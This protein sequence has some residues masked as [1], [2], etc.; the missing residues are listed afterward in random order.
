M[1]TNTAKEGM[2]E[3]QIDHCATK[4]IEDLRDLYNKAKEFIAVV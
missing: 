3:Q 4:E 2:W 1:G